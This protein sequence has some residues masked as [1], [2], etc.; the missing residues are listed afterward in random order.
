KVEKEKIILGLDPGTNVMGY[1]VIMIRGSKVTLLQ[2]GVIQLSKYAGHELRLKK[3]FERVTALVDEFN[4]DEVA[5][6]A[7]FF[8][9]NVQ[10]ML[11]LGRAQG[12]AM[13]AALARQVPIIEYAPK[14]VK[15]SV[16]GNGNASKEQVARMLMSL[17]ALKEL[18]KLLDATDA[19]AVAL[20]HH[21]QKASTKTTAP[22]WER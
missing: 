15:Q 1:G 6:E 22:S 4:P 18:P 5:L 9:K 21:Y 19:L 7:P 10:S 13:A 2:F 14:K 20:C 8:G 3:I 16:T 11:K 17:F 12:V